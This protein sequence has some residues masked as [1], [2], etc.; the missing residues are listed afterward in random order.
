M[1]DNHGLTLTHV[2]DGMFST[3]TEELGFRQGHMNCDPC[4]RHK[5]DASDEE[6]S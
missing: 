1:I 4:K 5:R 6:Q 2:M 3:K